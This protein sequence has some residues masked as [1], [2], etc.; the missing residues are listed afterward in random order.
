M[1]AVNLWHVFALEIGPANNMKL[2]KTFC[3]TVAMALATPL[4]S[5]SAGIENFDA[6]WLFLP[7]DASGADQTAFNDTVWHAVDLPHDWSIAG[8]FAET[9]RTGGAGAFLPGGAVWYRK[10]FS[11]PA[12]LAKESVSIQFDGVMQNSDVWVNGFHLGHRPYGYVSFSYELT[13]HLNFDKDNVIAVRADTSAQPASRWYSGAGIYRHVRLAVTDPDPALDQHGVFLSTPE[14]TAAEATIQADI[15]VTNETKSTGK[16]TV[17]TTILDPDGKA[18]AELTTSETD[19]KHSQT[20][21]VQQIKISTPQLWNLDDP[22]LYQA[23]TRIESQGRILDEQTNAFGIRDAH[24]E[25]ATGFWLNGKNFKLN[26]AS[27]STPMAVRLARPS[28]S[29]SGKRASKICGPS[30]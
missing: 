16:I 5:R 1:F 9:N 6:Q 13:G 2:F 15:A 24:F 11:L 3:L 21:S 14:A 28:P 22:K 23:I 30:V 12:D 20:G 25:P 19:Q 27:A 17:T 10:H 8:P 29:A 26:G 18:V 7:S 4:T